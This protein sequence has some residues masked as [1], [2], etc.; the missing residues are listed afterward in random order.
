[1]GMGSQKLLG[2]RYRFIRLIG[3]DEH[4]KTYLMADTHYPG[5][6]Q[7]IVK[8]LKLPARNPMTLQFLS[9]MLKAKV[10]MLESLGEHERIP[11]TLA[12]FEEHQDF[13]VV[14][15]YIVGVSL[16]ELLHKT[17]CLQESELLRLLQ[18]ILETLDFVHARGVIH[19]SIKPGNIILRQQDHRWVLIDFGL[20][21]EVN[22]SMAMTTNNGKTTARPYSETAYAAPEQRQGTPS[23]GTDIFALGIVVLQAATGCNAQQLPAAEDNDHPHKVQSCLA[24]APDLS[25]RLRR[26]LQR[27]THPNPNQRYQK[28]REVLADLSDGHVQHSPPSREMTDS[29]D[30]AGLARWRSSWLPAAAVSLFILGLLGA[31]LVLRIPQKL[32]ATWRMQQAEAAQAAG[33]MDQAIDLY[34]QILKLNPDRT[35]AWIQRSQLHSQAGDTSSALSDLTTAI[36]QSPQSVNL[37]YDRGNL[38]FQVGDL[39]GA[40]A[41][42]T[43]A[44]R[45]DPT[46]VDAYINRGSARA[47]W[48]DEQGAIDD[49][50]EAINRELAPDKQAAAYLNRCL[51]QSNLGNHQ[52]AL[53]DCT[54]AI[55]LRPGESLAYE[56]RGLV[57]RRLGDLDG[58]MKDYSIAIEINPDSPEPYYN[59]GLARKDLG[60]LAG[61]MEDFD[62]ALQLDPDHVFARYDRGLLALQQGKPEAALKDLEMAASRCL[63]LGRLSCYDDAQFHINDIKAELS[64]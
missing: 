47:Q 23:L 56:N 32:T 52:A 53:E 41:D 26:V 18:D 48:G 64:S 2:G 59:R 50:T 30:A 33:Q 60:D 22:A 14:Q 21:K 51:S 34:D 17:P 40:I 15:E 42:Y 19:R 37:Y 36:E 25:K 55:N 57:R 8:H 49:Y 6:P 24:K 29:T 20:V 1:M 61:A 12:Y 44:I 9:K 39:Q 43:E 27:M 38:R 7:C 45:L 54:Q 58:A 16:K 10:D 28:A 5:H 46:F 31:G 11:K 4:Y 35:E 3:A 13:Y 63:E 62:Q